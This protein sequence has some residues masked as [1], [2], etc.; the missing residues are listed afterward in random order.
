M[1]PQE[2]IEKLGRVKVTVEVLDSWETGKQKPTYI[3]LEQLAKIYKRPIALFLF[4]DPPEEK[5][6]QQSFRS[7]TAD[8]IENLS[9]DMRFLLRK[10]QSKQIS[11][12]ELAGGQN[13]K[14]RFLL[15]E[16]KFTESLAKGTVAS[17]VRDYLGV[18][19]L[20]QSSWT[21]VE[22]ALQS[23]RSHL[24]DCGIFIFKDSFGEKNDD[25]SGFCLHDE[26]FPII[27]INNNKPKS[28]QIFTL[29][30]EL[31][32]LL[33]E[34]G[35]ID[36]RQNDYIDSLKGRNKRIEIDCN[37]FAGKFLVPDDHFE[38]QTNQITNITEQEI[39]HLAKYYK[40]SREVILRKFFDSNRVGQEF[41]N[42]MTT[43]WEKTRNPQKKDGGGNYYLT[44]KT[45]LSETFVDLAFRQ[46]YRRQITVDQLSDYIGIKTK[47]IEKF[48][49]VLIDGVRE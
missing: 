30:H 37:Q 32:H 35:G 34:M 27:Y 39:E 13:P 40:V 3:Q 38:S 12:K 8:L 46:Y 42:S 28:R 19:L 41:Y 14:D 31:A 9:H 47:N 6:A 2:T 33:F 43:E 7:L 29:F 44:A 23:W 24:E 18:D 5:T 45:Y 20:K 26:E 21:G 25:I 10:A 16:L 49:T 36:F 48:E 11:L 15:R 17:S 22:E 1:S 4:P